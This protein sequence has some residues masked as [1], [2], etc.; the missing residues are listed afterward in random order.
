VLA[1]VLAMISLLSIIST[2]IWTYV[3]N[4]NPGLADGKATTD[5]QSLLMLVS[6]LAAVASVAIGIITLVRARRGVAARG[7]A[8]AGLVI[9][10]VLTLI[11]LWGLLLLLSGAPIE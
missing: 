6:P 5:A 9:G 11:Y 8:I 7:M 1:F 3:T 2:D 4:S 10:G